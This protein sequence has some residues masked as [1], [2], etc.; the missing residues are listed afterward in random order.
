MKS[1]YIFTIVLLTLIA[2]LIACGDKTS[3]DTQAEKP[4][5]DATDAVSA[6]TPDTRKT[7]LSKDSNYPHKGSVVLALNLGGEKF[8]GLDGHDYVADDETVGGQIGFMDKMKG[9]QDSLLYQSYRV[10]DIK[11]QHPIKNGLYDIVFKFAEPQDI[12]SGERIFDVLAENKVVLNDL[13]VK[14][15]RDGNAFSALDR[16][17]TDVVVNDGV[18]NINF[19]ASVNQPVLSALIVR[20][21]T[22]PSKEWKLVWSD[23]FD[24]MGAPDATKWTHNLWPAKKVNDENQT[25]TDRLKNVRVENGNLVIEAHKEDFNDA[26]YTSGRIHSEGKGDLLYG[27]IDI[28]A[29]LPAGQGSW[30][31]I[32]MLPSDPFKY[33]TKCKTGDVWQGADEVCD[34]WPNSGEI[35]IMEHVGYDL[36]NVHGTVHNSF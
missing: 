7:I 28:R 9:S 24:Y 34:A 16:S 21:K 23:E 30:P 6:E 35:D 25:Y 31:A 27:K 22:K 26:E 18:L 32:W 3:T 8:S 15:A 5:A 14:S 33:A 17:V 4:M 36:N 29:K 1:K 20:N 11:I 13:D 10:G 12:E 19:K 2:S